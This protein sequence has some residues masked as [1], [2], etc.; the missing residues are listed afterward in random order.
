[1]VTSA[2]DFYLVLAIEIILSMN[3]HSHAAGKFHICVYRQHVDDHAD[4]D[5]F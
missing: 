4:K 2:T 5:L 1:L 3:T